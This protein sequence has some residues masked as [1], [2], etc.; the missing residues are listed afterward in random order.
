[1]TTTLVADSS[2]L[3][4]AALN[5]ERDR[6][7]ALAFLDAAASGL[8]AV[9]ARETVPVVAAVMEGAPVTWV[10]SAPYANIAIEFASSRGTSLYDA[11]PAMLARRH[12]L[13]LVST[14]RRL[15]SALRSTQAVVEPGEALGL[16]RGGVP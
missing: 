8:V 13:V 3:V 7:Q 14:D 15:M 6:P 2:V 16:L 9:V 10:P 1:L 4:A 12:G 11:L 5:D